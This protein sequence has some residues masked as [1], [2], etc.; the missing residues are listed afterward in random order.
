MKRFI[1]STTCA[2][3]LGLAMTAMAQTATPS[4]CTVTKFTDTSTYVLT[5][6]WGINDFNTVVGLASSASPKA[7]G[8]GFIRY[9]DNTYKT[10]TQWVTSAFHKRNYSGVTVGFYSN[11]GAGMHGVVIHGSTI[12]TVDFPGASDTRLYGIN[13]YGTIVGTYNTDTKAFKLKNGTFSSIHFPG[14]SQTIPYAVSDTGVVVGLYMVSG[15][16]KK[17]GFVLANGVYKTIDY[18][19]ANS[20]GSYATDINAAGEIVGVHSTSTTTSA[21]AGYIYKNGAFQSYSVPNSTTTRILGLNNKGTITGEFSDATF[22]NGG[23][24]RSCQ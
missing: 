5:Q 11:G 14:S 1:A 9:S 19:N 4:T 3:L 20:V 8:Y 23:F 13:K 10:Y 2:A 17:H 15:S 24:I 21:N 18:P 12:Q 16:G 7:F 22:E 6:P